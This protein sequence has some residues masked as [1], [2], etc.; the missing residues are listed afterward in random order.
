MHINETRLTGN[1]ARNAEETFTKQG[2]RM[3]TF[4]IGHTQ[5]E[6]TMWIKVK[7]FE[8][9]RP[10]SKYLCDD[11]KRVRKGCQ[12]YVEGPISLNEYT[13]KDGEYKANLQIIANRLAIIEKA[14]KTYDP[15]ATIPTATMVSFEDVPF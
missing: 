6:E 15:N 12:V 3:V 9:D 2:K 13:G 11:A 10:G 4:T 1:A 7:V 8:N 14:P 5:K